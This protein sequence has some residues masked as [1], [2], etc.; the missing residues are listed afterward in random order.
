MPGKQMEGDNRQRRTRARDAR[1]EGETASE[2]GE[3][4]GASKQRNE[5]NAN[6]EHDSDVANIRRGKQQVIRQNSPETRPRSRP[7]RKD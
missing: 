2:R 3:T 5:T 7:N 6:E 1:N 4:F